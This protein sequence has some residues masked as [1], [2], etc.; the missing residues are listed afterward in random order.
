MLM[1]AFR[2]P[3][4]DRPR[5]EEGKS[6][7]H[8]S[9]ADGSCV[10]MKRDHLGWRGLRMKKDRDE[11]RGFKGK[12][13]LSSGTLLPRSRGLSLPYPGDGPCDLGQVRLGR[14]WVRPKMLMGWVV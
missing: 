5:A 13:V 8:Q 2:P 9:C 4:L 11:R 10:E 3:D 6:W 1:P 7:V 12:R 14:S